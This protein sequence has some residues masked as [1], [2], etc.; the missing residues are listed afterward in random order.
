[1]QA[2]HQSTAN[3]LRLGQLDVIRGLAI[4][5]IL[6]VNIFAFAW[7]P[8]HAHLL[9][10]H[11]GGYSSLDEWLFT[12]S[13][14]FVMGRFLTLFSLLFG[15]S[16]LLV[17]QQYG[18]EYLQRRLNWLLLF[19]LLHISFIWF[20]DILLWYALSGL[21][22]VKRGYLLLDSRQLLRKGLMFFAI[23]F[24][25]PLLSSLMLLSTGEHPIGIMTAEQL[26]ASIALWTGPAAGQWLQMLSLNLTML[27]AFVLCLLWLGV[28]LMLLGAGLYKRGW[29]SHGYSARVTFSL[30]L[31]GIAISAGVQ[32]A[33]AATG[34]Q[35][36]LNI[37]LPTT[38]LAALLMALA[39]ASLIIRYNRPWLQRWL[40]PCGRMAFTLYLSQSLLMVLL[41]RVIQ[42]D[43]FATLDRAP[44]LGIATAMIMLQLVFCRWYLQHFAQGPLE[45]LWRRLSKQPT[46]E[47]T[48]NTHTE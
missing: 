15:V 41:F 14:L 39:Y 42:P 37:T 1:M 32:L 7:P 11:D 38:Y 17:V 31:L 30:L 23:G 5:G 45:W 28:G 25:V 35:L 46:A 47:H 6:L 40:A 20:G 24:I 4:L 19:G 22:I 13:Q 9:Y 10:W 44:L 2:T 48:A 43:W 33:D 34:Y 36:A 21:F 8:E 3:H 27:L 12:A 16:L 18:A 26:A 29:F